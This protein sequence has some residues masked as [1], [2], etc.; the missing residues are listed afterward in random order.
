MCIDSENGMIGSDDAYISLYGIH[1]I[2]NPEG[3]PS[4]LVSESI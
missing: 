1:V 3:I 2:L 4:G